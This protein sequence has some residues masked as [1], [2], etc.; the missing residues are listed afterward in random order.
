MS[1]RIVLAIAVSMLLASC[2]STKKYNALE[3][4]NNKLKKEY[5]VAL[6]E[7]EALKD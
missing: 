3:T 1:K 7:L 2:V 4:S 5:R 6:A